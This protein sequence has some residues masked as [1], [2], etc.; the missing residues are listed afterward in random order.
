MIPCTC[1]FLTRRSASDP[2]GARKAISTYPAS[3]ARQR[4]PTW[5][6]FIPVTDTWQK[7]PTLPR[8]ANPAE[9]SSSG[10][11]LR[12]LNS[13]EI[14]ARARESM[15]QAGLPLIPGSGVLKESDEQ[16]EKIASKV[17]FPL[18]VKAVAGGGGK[19][20][21]SGQPTR[22]TPTKPWRRLNRKPT[23]RLAHRTCILSDFWTTLDTWSFKFW[24]MNMA[25]LSTWESVSVPFSAAIRN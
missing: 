1:A 2:P 3:S 12:P 16:I 10:P 18:I 7:M 11:R 8:S 9:S 6:H 5:I 25:T 20:N 4:L 13:W 17:G 19:R 14:K 22:S 23:A 24:L 21:E 15:K